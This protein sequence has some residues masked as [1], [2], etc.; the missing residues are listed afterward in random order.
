MVD[1]PLRVID[2]YLGENQLN[3]LLNL[4]KMVK[5]STLVDCS[6]IY[7]EIKQVFDNSIGNLDTK[8]FDL[9][10][11]PGDERFVVKKTEDIAKIGQYT[12]YVDIWPTNYSDNHI[13]GDPFVVN[14]KSPCTPEYLDM[15]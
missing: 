14:I 7:I 3:R 5:L 15:V 11:N 10:Q 9:I 1:Y 12:F 6:R 8:M 4:Q 13:K 2:Y